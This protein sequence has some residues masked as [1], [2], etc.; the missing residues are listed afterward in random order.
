MN[1]TYETN[2]KNPR[3]QLAIIDTLSSA[4]FKK[5]KQGNSFNEIPFELKKHP[6]E[7]S[8]SLT[9][10]AYVV[11]FD[12][13]PTAVKTSQI[14]YFTDFKSIK[15]LHATAFTQVAGSGGS[16]VGVNWILDSLTNKIERIDGYYE[17]FDH[18]SVSKDKSKLICSAS[19][20][21][22]ERGAEIK[23]LTINWDKNNYALQYL[24]DFRTDEWS[25]GECY[26]LDET[27][28]AVSTYASFDC[29]YNATKGANEEMKLQKGANCTPTFVVL[30]IKKTNS[31]NGQ[32][33]KNEN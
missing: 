33:Q 19:N 28:M 17:H 11:E 18:I 13:S 14:D 25:V 20:Q 30:K 1:G 29:H 10:A 31:K 16:G 23:V 21:Y 3:F 6:N 32:E 22:G 12:H 8:F 5:I 26:M 27:K 7:K 2:H 15:K 24:L 4:D 9:T